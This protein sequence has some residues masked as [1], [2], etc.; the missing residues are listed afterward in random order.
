VF[1]EILARLAAAL[2]RHGIPAMVIGGQAVLLY[3]E[4]RLTRDI[5][6]TLGVGTD[7]LPSVLDLLPEIPLRALPPELEAFVNRTM[8]LPALHEATGVRVD[9]VFSF[10]PYEQEAIARARAVVLGGRQVRFASPEDV[11]IHKIF[12]GRPRDLEDAA[13]IVRNQ[14]DL[15]H[16]YIRRWLGQFDEGQD[17]PVFLARFAA[18]TE[19]GNAMA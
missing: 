15:D 13:T 18:I 19:P 11:V 5:D 14:P 4:P 3:G 17:K 10:T 6:V 1:E 2:E 9:L 7:R 8:V 12:A 16:G